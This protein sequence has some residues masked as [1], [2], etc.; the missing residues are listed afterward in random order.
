MVQIKALNATL[1]F[2]TPRE[3]R[4]LSVASKDCELLGMTKARLVK[5]TTSQI[6]ATKRIMNHCLD[7]MRCLKEQYIS[8][9]RLSKLFFRLAVDDDAHYSFDDTLALIYELEAVRKAWASAIRDLHTLLDTQFDGWQLWLQRGNPDV[10][11]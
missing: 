11:P 6:A 8:M 4:A 3:R 5:A 9:M 2:L 10:T 7:R 1:S